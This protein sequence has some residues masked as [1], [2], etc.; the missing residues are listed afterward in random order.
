MW[1]NDLLKRVQSMDHPA[2][3][4]PH[5]IRVYESTLKLAKEENLSL[6]QDALFAA[7]LLHDI[8]A[9]EPYK[10]TGQDHGEVSA[11]LAEEILTPL[12]FTPENVDL[13]MEIIRG[14]MFYVKPSQVKEAVVFHDADTLDFMGYIGIT[15]ILSLV[16]KDDWAP[17]LDRA[18]ELI[19]RLAKE[20]S[21]SLC[22]PSARKIGEERKREMLTYLKFLSRQTGS[23]EYL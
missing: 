9:N 2:W 5:F 21:E 17:N 20:L 7:S 18:V 16:G 19:A 6:N 13:V 8:G 12:G 4:F 11:Q 15:R 22:L 23:F 1:K 14:H 10:K 3:G